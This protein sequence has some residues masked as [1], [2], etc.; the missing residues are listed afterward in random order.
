MNDN[1]M[2]AKKVALCRF[3]FVDKISYTIYFYQTLAQVR[4]CFLSDER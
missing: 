3:A 2:A 1:K 4:I